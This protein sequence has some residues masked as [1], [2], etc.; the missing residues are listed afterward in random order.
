MADPIKEAFHK[1]KEDI[2]SLREDILNITQELKTLREEINRTFN[3][4]DRPTDS[5]TI[6]T[7]KPTMT[8]PEQTE[9]TFLPT[10][11][12]TIENK[13]PLYSLKSQNTDISTGNRG[14]P[15]DRQTNQQTDRQSTEFA[16]IPHPQEIMDP[17]TKMDQVAQV[18]NS[19]DALKKDLRR[20]FKQLTE[21]EMLIFST[22]YQLTDQGI[23]VD[24][25][26]LAEKTRLSESSMRDYTQKLIRKG[27]PIQKVRE[28]NKKVTLSIP[29]EFKRMATLDT[30]L[31]LRNL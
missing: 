6:P 20:Q 29:T 18:L 15:T 25:P 4:T 9:A 24:Y 30:I 28:N 8:V 10:M 31:S 22:I 7:M 1:V 3:P 27:I 14:V 11:T 13:E 26:L 19:L 23:E 5:Q 16:L 17:L 12:P 21:Q 2:Q